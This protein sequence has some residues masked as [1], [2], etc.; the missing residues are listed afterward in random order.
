MILETSQPFSVLRDTNESAET[1]TVR[2]MQSFTL[3]RA[4]E[5][6]LALGA[7]SRQGA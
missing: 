6:Y 7:G 1:A 3:A 5:N 2:L 4:F